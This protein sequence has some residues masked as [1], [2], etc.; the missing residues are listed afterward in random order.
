MPKL[1]S[2]LELEELRKG[3]VSKRDPNRLCFT[4]CSGT[5]CLAIGSKQTFAAFEKELEKQG[6]KDRADLKP[7][8]CPGF[9]EQGRR[10]SAS[11]T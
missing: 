9:C 5:A 11:S 4:V 6:L 10:R 7:T 8:G 2:A 3:V 1:K